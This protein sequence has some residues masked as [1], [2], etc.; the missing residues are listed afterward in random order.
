M[1]A[2]Q[3]GHLEMV[4]C[5]IENRADIEARDEQNDTALILAAEKG[6]VEI[7]NFLLKNGVS[8]TQRAEALTRATLKG[9]LEVVNCLRVELI[10]EATTAYLNWRAAEATGHRFFNRFSHWYHGCS[11]I[12]RTENILQSIQEGLSPTQLMQEVRLAVKDSSHRKHSY[13]R[14][15]F[16]V[17]KGPAIKTV[18]NQ[19]DEEFLELKTD[20][21][22]N[23]DQE[24]LSI[25][26][27]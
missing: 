22:A 5:A 3:A 26:S 15:I 23:Y 19:S 25:N 12:K 14:Y 4:K 13:S 18:N 6:H 24:F 2:A 17:F 10:K 21:L 8:P 27:I 11:G 9:Q 1:F 16:D 20:F 7:V